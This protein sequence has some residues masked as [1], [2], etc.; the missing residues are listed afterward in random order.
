L[1]SANYKDGGQLILALYA[2]PTCPGVSHIGCQVLVK[3]WVK[4]RDRFFALLMP[5]EL[6][7]VL[8]SLFHQDAVFLCIAK[9]R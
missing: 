4:R 6:G 9:R 1:S 5:T 3:R 7:H 2:S 8:A